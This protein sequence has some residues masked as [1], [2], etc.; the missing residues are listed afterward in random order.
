M[1]KDKVKN[2]LV[3]AQKR[4]GDTVVSIPTFRAIRN[5][6]PQS[7]ITVFAPSYI[8]DIVER[9][10]EIDHIIEFDSGL[11]LFKKAK[12]IRKFSGS[13][14]ELAID[15]TC[16]YTMEGAL[17]SYLS[18]AKYRVGYDTFGRG[19]LFNKSVP[20]KNRS[21]P[22]TE[23]ILEIARSIDLDTKDK[24]LK[25]AP[26]DLAQKEARQFLREHK[27]TE[28]DLLIGIHPGGHYPTQR[29]FP[30]RFGQLADELM[31]K[32]HLKIVFLG[33]P[34]ENEQ[35]EKISKTMQNTPMIFTHQPVRN[36]LSLIQSCHLLICNNSGPLH[37]A[38]AL[39]TPTVSLMGPTQPER[40]WP[41]GEG[42]TVL[43]KDLSCMP[44]NEG[45]CERKTIECL[46]LITVGDVLE[47]VD[48]QLSKIKLKDRK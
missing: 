28:E 9:I 41:Q 6:L 42:H 37:L 10:G 3:I 44:C 19:L 20:H 12:K 43:R 26:S 11:S 29:W 48:N 14:Y 33:G 36:L 40:W 32:D 38:T 13:P 23:E 17:L 16:D 5:G 34:K 46:K 47:A 18:R 15:L 7:R 35:I 8:R 4:M 27:V 24:S 22:M 39:G 45:I 31:R 21:I 30:E 2:I 25:I 1:E